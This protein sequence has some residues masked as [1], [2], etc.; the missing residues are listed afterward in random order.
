VAVD[1]SGNV[2]VTDS[3]FQGVFELYAT[4]G[5]VVAPATPHQ[6]QGLGG[7]P[8]AIVV[9][10]ND[11]YYVA[12][13]LAGYNY[14]R[15]FLPGGG[16]ITPDVA[17][18][19]AGVTGLALDAN[20]NVYAA[21]NDANVYV[22][23]PTGPTIYA[24]PALLSSIFVEATGVALDGY[25]NIYVSDDGTGKVTKLDF[26]DLPTLNFPTSTAEHTQDISDGIPYFTLVNAGN[27]TLNFT[28][29]ASGTTNAT[30]IETSYSFDATTTCPVLNSSGIATE[31]TGSLTTLLA[32]T[33][34]IYA[35]D[36]TPD[37]TGTVTGF[38]FLMDNNLNGNPA[39]TFQEITVTGHGH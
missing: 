8:D 20:G 9:D 4:N 1:G 11:N 36:F 28:T 32:N 26:A 18:G 21:D 27:A 37:N 19:L 29:P 5:V 30:T 22:I 39:S 13:N 31:G 34:C 7:N 38:V 3:Y 6:L 35:L 25:G 14:V 17:S 10:V 2:F 33:S 15:K 12:N 16:Y 23:K 24:A